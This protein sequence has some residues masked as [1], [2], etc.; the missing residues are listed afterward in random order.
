LLK[1]VKVTL[2]ARLGSGLKAASIKK[3]W[4]CESGIVHSV[5]LTLKWGLWAKVYR[6][7]LSTNSWSIEMIT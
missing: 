3:G 7:V 1:R 2:F 5:I 6:I 4:S